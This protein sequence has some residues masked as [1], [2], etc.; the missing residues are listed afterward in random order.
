MKL[1]ECIQK[2]KSEKPNAFG[3]DT[4]TGFVNELE[5]MIQDYLGVNPAEFIVYDWTEDGGKEL[6]VKHPHDVMYKSYLKAKIDYANEEYYS[7]QN[8]QAQFTADYE[9]WQAYAM[10]SGLV[11]PDI[12]SRITNWW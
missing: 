7:Y 9:E 8:N 6:I 3:E 4:L 11:K 2:V 1:S 12:P 10:R 5:A